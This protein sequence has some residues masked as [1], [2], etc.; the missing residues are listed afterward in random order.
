MGKCSTEPVQVQMIVSGKRLDLEVDT[1]GAL[2]LMRTY[3]NEPIEVMRTLNVPVQDEGQ[4]KK[5][6][7][8]V[9]AGDDPTLLGRNWSNHITLYNFSLLIQQLVF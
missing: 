8:V 9:V 2:S 7:L 5:L 6:V 1:G 4:L 3:T